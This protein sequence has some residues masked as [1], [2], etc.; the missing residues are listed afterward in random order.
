MSQNI[1]ININVEACNVSML[2][3]S[4]VNIKSMIFVLIYTVFTH[5]TVGALRF[6]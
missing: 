6:N 2:R 1:H 4:S 5:T 3:Y